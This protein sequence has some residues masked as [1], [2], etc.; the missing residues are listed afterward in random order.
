M[1]SVLFEIDFHRSVNLGPLGDVT[2]F[3]VGLLL[4][5]SCLFG[6]AAL[7]IFGIKRIPLNGLLAWAG[8]TLVIML[9]PLFLHKIPVYGYGA[10]LFVG[11]VSATGVASRRI[12]QLGY[13]GEMAWDIAIWLFVAG[14]VGAR[15]FF[16]I[17]YPDRVFQPDMNL[18][19]KL[20][21]L[22][23][24][25]DGGIVFYGGLIGGVLAFL[26]YCYK[27]KVNALAFADIVITSLFIGMMFGRIGCLLHG[28]CFG[29]YCTLPWAITFPPESVP[30]R[31]LYARGFLDNLQVSSLPLHPTQIYS[32]IGCALLVVLTWTYYPF[33]QKDGS[34]LLLGWLTYP[35]HRFIVEFLRGDELGQFGTSLTIS[36]WVSMGLFVGGI[37]FAVWL[38]FQPAKLGTLIRDEGVSS[39]HRGAAATAA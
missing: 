22:F 31:E 33:R 19:Q 12:R 21:S 26:A 28:C 18:R 11:F 16:V 1:R 32:A 25:P 39:V 8:V 37:L 27:K 24:L 10:M 14:I 34:V 5:L 7:L 30:V 4:A 9:V 35:M 38:H 20:I 29:D 15:M 13:D 36:Q 3:G 17:Q 23:M 6:L 2:V